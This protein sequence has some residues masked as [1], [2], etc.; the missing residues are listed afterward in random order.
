LPAKANSAKTVKES[1][2]I[3]LQYKYTVTNIYPKSTIDCVVHTS[4]NSLCRL[5]KCI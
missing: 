3:I 1:V 4:Q 2:L 5:A